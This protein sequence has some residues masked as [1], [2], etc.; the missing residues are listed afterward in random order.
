VPTCKNGGEQ[1]ERERE[2]G[3]GNRF[4]IHQIINKRKEK[5]RKK[6]KR[7]FH[8]KEAKHNGRCGC[9]VFVSYFLSFLFFPGS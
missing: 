1:R 9:C 4:R 8:K 3:E 2:K 6:R 7:N 5:E